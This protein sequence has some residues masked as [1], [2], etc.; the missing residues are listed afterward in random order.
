MPLLK[1]EAAKLTNDSVQSGIVETL[2]E[3]GASEVLAQLGFKPFE[4]DGYA[5]VHEKSLPTSN[6]IADPYGT[7]IVNDTGENTRKLVEARLLIRNADTAKIDIIGKSDINDQRANDIMKAA[8]KM[9]KDFMF[10]MFHGL[11]TRNNF[12]GIEYWLS[13][14]ASEGFTEQVI[15][16]TNTGL[17]TGTKQNLSLAMVDDLLSRNFGTPFQVIYSDRATRNEFKSLLN[18]LGGNMAPTLMSDTF[19]MPVMTYDGV[20]WIVLD[21]VGAVKSGVCNVTA[22]DATLTID[23]TLDPYWI[24]FTNLDVGRSISVT[25]AGTAAAVHTT[26]IA[27]VTNESEIEMTAVAVTTASDTPFTVAATNVIYTATFDDNDALACIFHANRG[28]PANAGEYYGPIAGFDA[29]ELNTLEDSPR[30]RTRL[31]FFGNIVS[32]NPYA[33]GRLSHFSLA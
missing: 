15:Y 2:I 1:T 10:Q 3:K 20:P 27:S 23:A 14:Y 13:Y 8:K 29:E 26:T 32:H 6:S 9:A 22:T 25:G 18:A 30:L 19:G 21:P 17:V 7:T 12:N 24:G 33:Q 31:D 11:S 16:G 5:F 4:G 28:V